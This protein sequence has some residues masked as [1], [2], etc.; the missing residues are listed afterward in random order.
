MLHRLDVCAG[1]VKTRTVSRGQQNT[2]VSS[3]G[4]S[5][6]GDGT[7]GIGRGGRGMGSKVTVLRPAPGAVPI[8]RHDRL[9][10]GEQVNKAV[11][12][13]QARDLSHRIESMC[14]ENPALALE[15]V[16]DIA[17]TVSG[18]SL[19]GRSLSDLE[20]LRVEAVF[21]ALQRVFERR[22]AHN[23]DART[24]AE[25]S[26]EDDDD[27]DDDGLCGDVLLAMAK[28][29][30]GSGSARLLLAFC[31]FLL[32]KRHLVDRDIDL[33]VQEVAAFRAEDETGAAVAYRSHPLLGG[34][35][36]GAAPGAVGGGEQKH[37]SDGLAAAAAAVDNG[38]GSVGG[39]GGGVAGCGDGYDGNVLSEIR[40]TVLGLLTKES[41]AV[42]LLP[43]LDQAAADQEAR[44]H[45]STN[46]IEYGTYQGGGGEGSGYGS[47]RGDSLGEDATYTV[48]LCAPF[49]PTDGDFEVRVSAPAEHV[50]ASE[51]VVELVEFK[52]TPLQEERRLEA[53]EEGKTFTE[54]SAAS[55][56]TSH[57]YRALVQKF[58]GDK[59]T[60]V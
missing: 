9:S 54:M 35:I 11:A 57:H 42:V 7:G 4:G 6:G 47:G 2:S 59:I 33:E 60:R 43:F 30:F 53:K 14:L 55:R 12:R 52:E 36:L 8:A 1:Y 26:G 20:L 13:L 19:D 15:V 18:T 58:L 38:A 34:S 39:A 24:R 17:G 48:S 41:E 45:T 3:G 31:T 27:A 21:T 56:T 22:V 23:Q 44:L 50:K 28:L 49:V 51:C 29:A 25:R 40:D 37:A 16:A 10:V 46:D 5:S 32:A